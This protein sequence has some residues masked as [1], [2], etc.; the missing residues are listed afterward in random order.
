MRGY[1]YGA[2]F[3]ARRRIPIAVIVCRNEGVCSTVFSVSPSKPNYGFLIFESSFLILQ[4]RK[5]DAFILQVAFSRVIH[6]M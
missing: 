6:E 5:G 1:L 4:N 2:H 3:Y